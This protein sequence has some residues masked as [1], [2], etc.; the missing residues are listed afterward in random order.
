MDKFLAQPQFVAN[1]VTIYNLSSGAVPLVFTANE[2]VT[3]VTAATADL[4]NAGGPNS[5]LVYQDFS[6]A[7]SP[8]QCLIVA[9][10]GPSNEKTGVAP[11]V[12]GVFVFD[13]DAIMQA[14][15][16]ALPAASL[17][18]PLT[19]FA[20]VGMAIQ[21]G[22]GDLFV[23]TPSSNGGNPAVTIYPKATGGTWSSEG[24]TS[25][26]SYNLGGWATTPSNFAFDRHGFLWMTS[27]GSTPAE[28]YLACFT[29][30][31]GPIVNT[32]SPP[33]TPLPVPPSATPEFWFANNTSLGG[34]AGL[35]KVTQVSTDPPITSSEPASLYGLSSP[36]GVAF[37]PDGNLWVCS[38][39]EEYQGSDANLKFSG[40]GGGSILMIRAAYLDSLLFPAP[41][42]DQT[43]IYLND[44][45]SG[46]AIVYYLGDASQP[47]GLFFDGYTLYLNDENA[48][49]D[50]SGNPVVWTTTVSD[51]AP[52][53]FTRVA[54]PGA[55]YVETSNPGNGTMAAFNYTRGAT[56]SQLLI[57]DGIWDSQ[58]TEPDELPSGD[59]AWESPD[60]G[61]FTTPQTGLMATS[62]LNGSINYSDLSGAEAYVYVRITNI[63]AAASFGT[64]VLKVYWAHAS[65]ALQWPNPWDGLMADT[66][67][68]NSPALGG[69]VG[70][71]TVPVLQPGT[72]AVVQVDWTDVPPPLGYSDEDGDVKLQ[73]HFCLLARIEGEGAYPFGMTEPEQWNFN[74]YGNLLPDQG[75]LA[76]NVLNNRGIAWRNV[77]ITEDTGQ[78]VIN[79][80]LGVLGGNYGLADK[81]IGFEIQTLG[82]SGKP[83]P[84]HANITLVAHG[85][86]LDRFLAAHERHKGWGCEHLGGRRFHVKDLRNGLQGIAA[87]AQRTLPFTLEFKLEAPR[88]DY[89]VRVIQY[90]EAHGQRIVV[91]GQTFVFGE[92][93]GFPVRRGHTKR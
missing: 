15:S 86:A 32:S 6:G 72:T 43:Q 3:A 16:G 70:S 14:G 92:V 56:P 10:I 62:A 91:G 68:T 54:Q 79:P 46:S 88:R 89:A 13:L 23:A 80:R 75:Y 51:G 25:T 18:L 21:P 58:G 87:P 33:P 35:L 28:N 24:N 31:A 4:P 83:E 36:E 17:A 2:A 40:A 20:P 42:A 77:Q 1:S 74:G 19:G 29:G 12:G 53:T 52:G 5:V 9:Y 69:P 8:K 67:A 39:N 84:V 59:N 34:T 55:S 11:Q 85:D 81:V 26:V 57:K 27:F 37:D 44:I 50:A 7:S 66:A 49:S 60:I 64:E 48:L 90:E 63:S 61:V 65:T 71:V 30:I 47:G 41:P 38:N 82:Q 22:T 93:V 76:T 78:I 45:P 73:D